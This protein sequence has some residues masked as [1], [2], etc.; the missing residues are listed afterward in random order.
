MASYMLQVVE[1]E[2]A[3]AG[4]L[5]PELDVVEVTG[6]RPLDNMDPLQGVRHSVNDSTS[7]LGISL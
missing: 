3:G 4:E 1:F 6:F 7:T 2:V 5:I